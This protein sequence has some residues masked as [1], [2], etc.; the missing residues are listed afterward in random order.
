MAGRSGSRLMGDMYNEKCSAISITSRRVM[1]E[2]LMPGAAGKVSSPIVMVARI[3]SLS[4]TI[5]TGS[6][7]GGLPA[8]NV[9]GG[10]S[11]DASIRPSRNSTGIRAPPSLNRTRAG[12][13]VSR[14]NVP[15]VP[16]RSGTHIALNSAP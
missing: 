11:I 3:A 15:C 16:S 12:R 2:T 8:T 1:P 10:P 13:V 4:S 14:K 6:V 7:S 5:L 9:F